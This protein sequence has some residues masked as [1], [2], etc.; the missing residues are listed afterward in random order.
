M[1]RE[2][3]EDIFSSFLELFLK[4]IL[5]L[6]NRNRQSKLVKICVV[7]RFESLWIVLDSF[8]SFWIVLD[9]FGSF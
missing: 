4:I 5:K 2:R 1:P 3:S 7:Y 9:R 8:G 6:L